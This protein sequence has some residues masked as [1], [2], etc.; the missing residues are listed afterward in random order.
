MLALGLGL[1]AALLWAVHDLLVRK[2][3][4]HMAILP[5]MLVV[6]AAGSVALMAPA[7][8]LRDDWAG[9]S[10]RAMALAAAGGLA[11]TV[12]IG[13]LYRAYSMAP[14]RIVAPVVGAYPILSL[15][16]A[17]LQGRPVTLADW[18]AVAA[19][20]GGIAIVSVFY[21]QQDETDPPSPLLAISWS[22][23]S[24]LGFA[25]TFALGHEAVREG[26]ELP[27]ILIT[28]LV[29]LG[30]TGLLCLRYHSRLS[31]LRGYWGLVIL[32]GVIDA[33]ALSAVTASGRLPQAEYASVSSSLFGVGT[34]LLAMVFLGE[35]LQRVQWIGVI[36]VFGGIAALTLQG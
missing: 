30:C 5:I 12:A 9:L 26:S 13:A 2:L 7:I 29:A 21:E 17:A 28:R 16:I 20:V 6:M 8:Y 31:T 33:I 3:S 4:Q 18:L 22:A 24:A 34:I 25:V 36:I 35:R 1:T 10:V 15:V 32:M 14:V 23:L 27:V 11:V 19:V